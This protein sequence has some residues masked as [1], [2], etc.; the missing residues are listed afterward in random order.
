MRH[1]LL[2][3]VRDSPPLED[4]V[5]QALYRHATLLSAKRLKG[6]SYLE[7][8]INEQTL[9]ELSDDL[10]CANLV[11]EYVPLFAASVA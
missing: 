5:R 10:L 9:D 7:L 6:N 3:V 8:D 2:V 11:V 4:L 1:H